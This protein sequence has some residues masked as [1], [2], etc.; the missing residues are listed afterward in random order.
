M[1][2]NHPPLSGATLIS[3]RKNMGY[4]VDDACKVLECPR[5]T[6]IR[7]ENGTL[8]VPRYIGL[9]TAALA[10]GISLYPNSSDK[11]L[12]PHD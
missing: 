12:L 4:T 7:W 1:T 2:P 9:A 6:W 5:A 3:W 8:P 11:D 10:L